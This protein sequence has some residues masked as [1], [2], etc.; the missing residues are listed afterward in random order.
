MTQN[1]N[2]FQGNSVTAT[3]VKQNGLRGIY[4][5][6]SM[7]RSKRPEAM[8]FVDLYCG[9]GENKLPGEIIAGSPISMLAGILDAVQH[10]LKKPPVG[11]WAC[12]FND[13][14]PGRATLL[15]PE[16]VMRWQA[17]NNLVV[18]PD[19]FQCTARDGSTFSMPI[20]YRT[21]SA[22]DAIECICNIMQVNRKSHIILMIDPNGPKDAP[23]VKTK[24]IWDRYPNRVEMIFHLG[25][26]VLKRVSKA[27]DVLGAESFAPMP[28]HIAALVDSFSE[29]DGWVRDPVGK[30]QWTMLL[31]SKFPPHNGW[32]T[33]DASFHKIQSEIGQ[34]VVRRLSLTKKELGGSAA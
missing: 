18:N 29:S 5:M 1:L 25:A 12:L 26:T 32:K 11:P 2:L 14:T 24:E 3:P 28:D 9:S 31:L 20:K 7:M 6:L 8:V 23:W 19:L 16:N 17:E 30:D 34:A 15:L 27:R 4:S 22:Q 10:R 13:I 21:G 33:I